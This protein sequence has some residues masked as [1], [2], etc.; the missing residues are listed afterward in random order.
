[1]TITTT[2]QYEQH[3]RAIFDLPL[4][5]TEAILPSAM[6]NLL[7]EEGYSG[8]AQYEGLDKVMDEKGVN[9][10]LYGKKLTKPFRK[11]GHVTLIGKDVEK[12]KQ[13]VEFVKKTLKVIA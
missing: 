3:L 7:G 9:V 13:K 6:V 4:G 8:I 1:M 12:L 5:H 11:M 2:S 10:H